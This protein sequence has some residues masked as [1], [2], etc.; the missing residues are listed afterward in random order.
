MLSKKLKNRIFHL[1]DDEDKKCP[2]CID[3]ITFNMCYVTECGHLFHNKCIF[4]AFKNSIKCP[5]CHTLQSN[6]ANTKEKEQDL[7]RKLRN[8]GIEED[9]AEYNISSSE[10]YNAELFA[11]AALINRLDIVMFIYRKY[12]GENL[13]LELALKNAFTNNNDTIIKYLID[14]IRHATE[15]NIDIIKKTISCAIDVDNQEILEYIE[16]FNEYSFIINN[17]KWL[18]AIKDGD[19]SAIDDYIDIG[20]A[21]EFDI[22]ESVE[23]ALRYKRLN[24]INQ[25]PIDIIHDDISDNDSIKNVMLD[26]VREN[27][28]QSIEYIIENIFTLGLSIDE[29]ALLVAVAYGYSDMV[30]LILN[31]CENISTVNSIELSV[32]RDNIIS[33]EII[34]AHYYNPDNV[35]IL[36]LAI[37]HHSLNV[38]KYLLAEDYYNV[39]A[40]NCALLRNPANIANME[41]LKILLYYN[42]DCRFDTLMSIPED[43]YPIN[44]KCEVKCHRSNI[45]IMTSSYND[46]ALHIAS[47]DGNLDAIKL[48]IKYGACI[49]ARDN[50]LIKNAVSGGYIDIINFVFGHKSFRNYDNINLNIKL[51]KKAIDTDKVNIFEL[52]DNKIIASNTSQYISNYNYMLKFAIS[53]NRVK[54]IEYLFS[55]KFKNNAINFVLDKLDI[56]KVK[57]I[58]ILKILLKND[59]KIK[60]YK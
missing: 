51:I 50:I 8:V 59:E 1:H 46:Y 37:D 45:N 20:I 35:S 26:L 15:P 24:I 29:H 27:D 56:D 47:R 55:S 33:L 4:K 10:G 42:A 36:Q 3:V 18:H 52:I 38:L 9:L 11:D 32:K 22:A 19:T 12:N 58:Q 14:Q 43:Q 60:W 2:I 39:N 41:V 34:L 5:L 57:N 48:L 53:T 31:R 40:N 23:Y 28:I 17:I 7:K 6:Y 21:G 13:P 49:C 54:I 16:S 25:L 30:S 44:H